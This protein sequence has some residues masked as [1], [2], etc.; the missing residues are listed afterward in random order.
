MWL[1]LRLTQKEHIDATTIKIDVFL[2]FCPRLVSEVTN[3][4]QVLMR[5]GLRDMK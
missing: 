4:E 2:L 3:H 5:P 1:S